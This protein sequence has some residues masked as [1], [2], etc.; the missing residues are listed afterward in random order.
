MLDCSIK[1]GFYK[2]K[3]KAKGRGKNENFPGLSAGCH[4]PRGIGSARGL[5]PRRR[6]HPPKGGLSP[7]AKDDG[8]APHRKVGLEGALPPE[9]REVRGPLSFLFFSYRFLKIFQDFG[10]EDKTKE[11]ADEPFLFH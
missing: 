2:P 8:E 9:A 4:A 6:K 7:P 1:S 5:A 11:L 10:P 3:P